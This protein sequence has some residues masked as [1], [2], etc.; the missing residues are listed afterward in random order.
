MTTAPTN[1]WPRYRIVEISVDDP[2]IANAQPDPDAAPWDTVP[3]FY[4]SDTRYLEDED[5]NSLRV[6]ALP[7][8]A[9]GEIKR[10]TH[11]L[12]FDVQLCSLVDTDRIE[13]A[14]VSTGTKVW[15]CGASV[16][17]A[18]GEPATCGLILREDG[19]GFGIRSAVLRV[20]TW[21]GTPPAGATHVML[22]VDRV[23]IEGA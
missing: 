5:P 2:E 23:E 6:L 9:S 3:R 17:A 1:I 10:G 11:D 16:I 19:W 20:S 22:L 21:T 14:S 4:R 7:C 18:V 12:T 13:G 8:D 15:A